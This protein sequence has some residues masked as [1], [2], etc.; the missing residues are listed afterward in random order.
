MVR[1]GFP[2][3]IPPRYKFLTAWRAMAEKECLG[4]GLRAPARL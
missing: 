3:Y 4:R 2:L 1:D